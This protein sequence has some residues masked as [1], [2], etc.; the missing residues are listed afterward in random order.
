MRDLFG[1]TPDD[2][3]ESASFRGLAIGIVTRNDDEDGLARVKVRFPWREEGESHW[4][5]LA[6][7]MAGGSR[8]ALF[9]PEVGD[10]VLVAFER[11]DPEHP[12]V[13]GALW[14]GVDRPPEH[15]RSTKNDLRKITSRSG[16]ELLFDDGK[17]GLVELRHASGHTVVIREDKIEILAGGSVK[18]V[19]DSAGT[20]V[21][22]RAQQSISVQAAAINLKADA[23]LNLQSGGTVNIKGT[24][25]NIN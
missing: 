1:E 23:E 12:Y 19:L 5:R 8:G 21:D 3:A 2:E 6:T 16:H 7:P 17:Q 4:A 13:L 20:S 10:E 14:N 22:V 11:D 18:I 9:V 25:V 24:V 15:D